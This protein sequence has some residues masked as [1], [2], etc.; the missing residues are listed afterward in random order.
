MAKEP[1]AQEGPGARSPA[2]RL[3]RWSPSPKTSPRKT[4]HGARQGELPN[5]VSVGWHHL[6][7]NPP[8]GARNPRTIPRAASCW[9][10]AR[11]G[12]G[13]CGEAAPWRLAGP[14]MAPKQREAARPGW[15]A[16]EARADARMDEARA[17]VAEVLAAKPANPSAEGQLRA[18]LAGLRDADCPGGTRASPWVAGSLHALP[19]N[20]PMVARTGDEPGKPFGRRRRCGRYHQPESRRQLPDFLRTLDR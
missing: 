18:T 4:G 17:V 16:D 15:Q 10:P 12:A 9:A 8:R 11:A 6:G 2:K 3:Q 14:R 1:R 5:L 19:A 20:S 13:D 7:K